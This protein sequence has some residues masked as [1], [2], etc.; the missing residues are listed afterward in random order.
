MKEIERMANLFEDLYNG[1]P[2]LG[3]TFV[4]T[5]GSI[6]VEEA[7]KRIFPNF[8]SIWKLVNHVTEW[9]LNILK[10]IQGEVI[11]TPEHNYFLPIN[12]CTDE[13]W[14]QDLKRL[15][16]SQR[17]WL[18]FLKTFREEDLEKIYPTNQQTYYE[19][20]HGILQHDAYHLGQ[21]RLLIKQ[22]RMMDTR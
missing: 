6:T 15:A 11:E 20:I 13:A 17:R 1:K 9:R 5:L 8:N 4:D 7:A 3:E 10:R 22:E 21:I 18:D 12:D 16:A 14:K 19:H 2:W